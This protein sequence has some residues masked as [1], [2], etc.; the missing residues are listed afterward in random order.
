MQGAFSG[1]EGHP[2]WN[3]HAESWVRW[4]LT[5]GGWRGIGVRG[6]QVSTCALSSGKKAVTSVLRQDIWSSS[7]YCVL[8]T[9]VHIVVP[10]STNKHISLVSSGPWHSKAPLSEQMWSCGD[11]SP[12]GFWTVRI[13]IP[14]EE[15]ESTDLSPPSF[16]QTLNVIILGL[17]SCGREDL[18]GPAPSAFRETAAK[19]SHL[20]GCHWPTRVSWG[21][22][23]TFFI[24]SIDKN[25]ILLPGA[26]A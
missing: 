20:E 17:G 3:P 8:C 23:V 19:Y 14:S 21:K 22:A 10:V 25:C 6:W 16:L 7:L 11:I 2:A 1:R 5:A 24:C 4:L 12:F 18:K 15:V 9:F 26:T 13:R